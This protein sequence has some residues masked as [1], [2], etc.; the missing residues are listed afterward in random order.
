MRVAIIGGSFNP[1]HNGHL[2]LADAVVKEFGY[3]KILFIPAFCSPDKKIYSGVSA[4][5]RLTMLELAI[6]NNPSFEIETCELERKGISYTIDTINYLYKKYNANIHTNNM[7]KQVSADVLNGKI[8]LVIGDDLEK[9]FCNWKN[10]KLLAQKT[11]IIV[12]H[13][14]M[15]SNSFDSTVV[16]FEKKELSNAIL[17][18]SSSGIRLAIQQKKAWRYFVPSDVY[19]YIEAKDLYGK[20]NE[21]SN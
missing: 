4:K 20:K 5:D 12:A 6:K 10:A 1:V 13:R 19:N 21:T 18:I 16:E 11:D 14:I 7:Q 3:D 2:A 17:P 8:G 15:Q 9:G